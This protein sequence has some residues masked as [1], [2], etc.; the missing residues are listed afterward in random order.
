MYVFLTSELVGGEWWASRPGRFTPWGKSSQCHWIGE[1]AGH[2]TGMD[3]VENRQIL[4]LSGLELRPVG[5]PVRRPVTQ[6][7]DS[8]TDA[9]RET[10][11]VYNIL[12][13]DARRGQ[14]GAVNWND[15][16]RFRGPV[17]GYC[18]GSHELSALMKQGEAMVDRVHES[19]IF[20]TWMKVNICKA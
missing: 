16:F 18:D 8:S 2:K 7:W 11:D 20:S 17:L 3:A 15:V 14:Y 13:G 4:P 19:T 1:W 10:K 6:R 12:I 5:R 9:R